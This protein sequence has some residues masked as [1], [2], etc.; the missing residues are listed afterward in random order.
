MQTL[1]KLKTSVTPYL[2]ARDASAAIDFYRAAFG[3]QETFRMRMDD[4]RIGHAEFTIEEA[5]F[6][7]A[8]EWPEVAALSPQTLGGTPVMLHLQVDDVDALFARAV[9]A[10][11]TP[12]R[13]VADQP[14]GNRSG[15]LSDPFGHRWMLSTPMDHIAGRKPTGPGASTDLL[16]GG[17]V[18]TVDLGSRPPVGE[19]DQTGQLFYFTLGVHDS[20][21]A[22]AF[23]SQLLDWQLEPGH[24]S[25]GFHI[26]NLEPPGGIHGG[27]PSSQT[28]LFFKTGDIDQ[29]VERVRQLGGQAEEPVE[30]PSGWSA[31]CRDDQGTEFYLSQPA[32]GYG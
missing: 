8:D 11:A 32:P 19:A 22:A 5:E 30:S 26:S 2:A 3:A 9:A 18:P 10:G 15:T 31:L 24:R 14:H 27:E 12:L 4:G 16:G 28:R 7:I 1:E 25:D 6:M 21:K 17:D 29:A 23:F 20:N 13:E